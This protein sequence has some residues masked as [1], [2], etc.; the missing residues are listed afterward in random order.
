MKTI[1]LQAYITHGHLTTPIPIERDGLYTITVEGPTEPLSSS[2]GSV[3]DGLHPLPV[4]ESP[5][6]RYGRDEL[7]DADGR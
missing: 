1:T 3:L 2:H 7:Y 6:Q 5:S 4:L